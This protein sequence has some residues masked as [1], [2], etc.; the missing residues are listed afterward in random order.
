MLKVFMF[1]VKN[2]ILKEPQNLGYHLEDFFRLSKK[3]QRKVLDKYFGVFSG[4]DIVNYF[5]SSEAGIKNFLIFI[6]MVLLRLMV[7]ILV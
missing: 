2:K 3:N 5:I 6:E 4:C 7:L 1:I